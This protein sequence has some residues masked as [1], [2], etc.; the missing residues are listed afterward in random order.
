MPHKTFNSSPS[1]IFRK[2]TPSSEQAIKTI[3]IDVEE[4]DLVIQKRLTK[5][6]EL[7]HRNNIEKAIE[8]INLLQLSDL[9]YRKLGAERNLSLFD[10]AI[11]KENLDIANAI[12]VRF[13]KLQAG[14]TRSQLK[15]LAIDFDGQEDT[16]L[17]LESCSTIMQPGSFNDYKNMVLQQRAIYLRGIAETSKNLRVYGFKKLNKLA[18]KEKLNVDIQTPLKAYK[19]ANLNHA[20][21]RPLYQIKSTFK[22]EWPYGSKQHMRYKKAIAAI[23]SADYIDQQIGLFRETAGTVYRLERF[24]QNISEEL[25]SKDELFSNDEGLKQSVVAVINKILSYSG[26]GYVKQL[27]THDKDCKEVLPNLTTTQEKAKLIQRSL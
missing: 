1:K 9:T 4:V 18:K 2:I 16:L 15:P 21:Y 5:I 19:E 3:N 17:F 27:I 20:Q 6:K 24:K 12:I 7:I 26:V 22:S 13:G 8:T 11:F 25:K 10:I 23:E 14:N